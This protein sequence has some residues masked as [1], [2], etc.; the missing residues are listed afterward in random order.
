VGLHLRAQAENKAVAREILKIQG[1]LGGHHRRAG[2]GDGDGGTEVYP[3]SPARGHRQRQKRVVLGLAGLE[4]VETQVFGCA[5][6]LVD[7]GEMLALDGESRVE[8]HLCL[9]RDE[10]ELASGLAAFEVTVRRIR[11]GEFV[12]AA[13]A[14]VEVVLT[15]PGKEAFGAPE[16]LLAGRRVVG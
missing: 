5:A 1:D 13:D 3:L 11:L 8:L 9:L 6:D 4:A 15:D 2:E 12:G 10:D 7:A 14:D 16:E